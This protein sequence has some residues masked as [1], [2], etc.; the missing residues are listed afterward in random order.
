MT[1]VQFKKPGGERDKATCDAD[2]LEVRAAQLS[3]LFR[4]S[5]AVDIL[6][7]AINRQFTGKIALVSSFGAES[8]ALLHLVARV[9]P[10]TPV[11]FLDTGKHFAQTIGYR[12]KLAT[13]LGLKDVR[14]ILPSTTDIEEKDPNGDLWQSD[15]DACCTI[16]KVRPLSSVLEGFDAWIT[17][18]KQFHG[19][20]RAALPVFE[21][22]S[23]HVK[24]NPIVRWDKDRLEA[25]TKEFDL[26]PHPLVAQGYPSI[27][28]WPCTHPS[29]DVDDPRAG[30]WRGAAKTECGI[31]LMGKKPESDA[32]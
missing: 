15:A 32:E 16:R 21:F 12:N 31:H 9:A 18:R 6:D 8:A 24:V 26:P 7:E 17:G 25:Y 27:G 2:E 3:S 5:E 19:G 30:R 23:P 11:I 1:V 22:S 28:C 13:T 20:G 4:V 10:H 29:S 14:N